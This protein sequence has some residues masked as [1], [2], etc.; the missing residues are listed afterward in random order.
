[1]NEYLMNG[2]LYSPEGEGGGTT[3]PT[4]PTE[5][6]TETKEQ[7]R[8]TQEATFTQDQLNNH[9]H[10]AKKKWDKE[11]QSLKQDVYSELGIKGPEDIERLTSLQEKLDH[12]EQGK[13]EAKGQFDKILDAQKKK[14]SDEISTLKSENVDI[15]SKYD[16]YRKKIALTN[17]ALK[18]G[19]DHS[20]IDMI[21]NFIEKDIKDVDDLTFQVVD[22]DG[23]PRL[24]PE[25]G[26]EITLETFVKGFLD[27]RPGL[28]QDSGTSGAGSSGGSRGS[29]M[30]LD[31]LREI[32]AEDQT[33]YAELRADGTAQRIISESS[34]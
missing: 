11:K 14:S 22:Y 5:T 2:K 10:H 15:S 8:E 34:Q 26:K 20:N 21:V 6:K 23:Q 7:P 18:A 13:L 9:V 28:L 33:K 12:E 4:E 1:M 17:V 24:D 25:S 27:D 19:A 16:S 29:K 3:E 31:Q 32:A 30:N